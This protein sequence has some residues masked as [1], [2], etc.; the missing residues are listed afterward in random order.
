MKIGSK[1]IEKL[2]IV[3]QGEGVIMSITDEKIMCR[4]DYEVEYI[5]VDEKNEVETKS[6]P[7]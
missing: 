7:T 6:V 1:N 5:H 4:A 3:K 2:N